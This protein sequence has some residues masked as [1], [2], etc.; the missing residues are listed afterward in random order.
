MS[1][2]RRYQDDEVAA[3]FEAAASPPAAGGTV[4]SGRGLTL[5]ELQAIGAEVGVPAARIA[6]AARRIDR[7][8]ELSVRR[9]YAGIPFAVGRTVDLPRAPTDRE[10]ETLLSE[11][12]TTFGA[13]GREASRGS[14]REW[15]NSNLHAYVE[16]AGSGYRLRLGTV[17]GNAQ[18]L[19]VGGT[20]ALLAAATTFAVEMFTIGS[21]SLIAEPGLLAAMGGGAMAWLAMRLPPWARRRQQ[22]MEHI[23]ARAL[24]ITA[25]PAD[26]SH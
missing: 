22:Q 17:K 5:A 18:P 20:V 2:E 16:P 24:E 19:A 14:S 1:D 8:A 3:I 12:R 21:V 13:R 26:D 7:P 6:E 11:L 15:T 25:A 9:A 10:W 23:A 4:A